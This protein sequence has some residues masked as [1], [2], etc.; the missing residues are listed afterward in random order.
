MISSTHCL[1]VSPLCLQLRYQK[2]LVARPPSQKACSQAPP[3]DS[4]TRRVSTSVKRGV[5]SLIDTLKQKRPV[6]EL[7]Q[8]SD[9]H[10]QRHALHA[11]NY[12]NVLYIP[13]WSHDEDEEDHEDEK[14]LMPRK[15]TLYSHTHKY[16]RST[17]QNSLSLPMSIMHIFAWEATLSS[18][19]AINR[20]RP[21]IRTVSSR[22]SLIKE[23]LIRRML[24]HI[25]T[26]KAACSFAQE[27][28]A[29]AWP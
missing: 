20:L 28:I 17:I 4:V 1:T 25:R 5:L 22:K 13:V 11:Y 2:C 23:K 15:Y 10:T 8:W 27:F 14:K 7:P 26:N 18:M 9:T 3:A 16:I 12:P 29:I 21:P 19:T 6:T 24:V